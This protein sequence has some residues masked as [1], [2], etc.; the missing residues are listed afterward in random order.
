MNLLPLGSIIEV[1]SHKVC[2]IGY[3]SD[4]KAAVSTAGYIVVSYPVGFTN[5]DKAFFIPHNTPME[6]IAQG[7]QSEASALVLDILAKGFE[8]A[9]DLS[10]DDLLKISAAI[11]NVAEQH[12]E[13]NEE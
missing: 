7:Y 1:N 10:R 3:T 5:I 2:I 6:V 13:A 11:K 12:K 4:D 8:A 9:K